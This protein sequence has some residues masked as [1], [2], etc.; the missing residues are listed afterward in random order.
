M[1]YCKGVYILQAFLKQFLHILLYIYFTCYSVLFNQYILLACINR[2]YIPSIKFVF[3]CYNLLLFN[4]IF[5]YVCVNCILDIIKSCQC[6]YFLLILKYFKRFLMQRLD[7]HGDRWRSASMPFDLQEPSQP[8]SS[9]V[10]S[11]SLQSPAS[12][13]KSPPKVIIIQ[14]HFYSYFFILILRNCWKC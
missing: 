10:T 3:Y 1:A 2:I 6:L 14:I 8:K 13:T 4:V 9:S 12:K 11:S 5:Y 7:N